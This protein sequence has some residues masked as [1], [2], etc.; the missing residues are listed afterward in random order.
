M[1]TKKFSS[2]V[3]LTEKLMKLFLYRRNSQG[4]QRSFNTDLELLMID[5]NTAYKGK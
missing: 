5:L 3:R 2:S 4:G 1:T